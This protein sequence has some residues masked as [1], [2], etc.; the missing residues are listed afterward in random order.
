MSVA[1]ILYEGQVME[2]AAVAMRTS[3][4]AVPRLP[5][6]CECAAVAINVMMVVHMS[7]AVIAFAV[8]MMQMKVAGL[9]KIAEQIRV[10]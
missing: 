8:V 1:I 9:M 2:L 7:L 10:R 3:T 6:G 4:D 5:A